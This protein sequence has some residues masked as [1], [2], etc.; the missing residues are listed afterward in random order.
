MRRMSAINRARS[1][2]LRAFRGVASADDVD[3]LDA[4]DAVSRDDLV[5]LAD[6]WLDPDGFR[7]V[8]TR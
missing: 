6:T 4:M 1:L 8:I 5:R 2:G 3:A 7:V